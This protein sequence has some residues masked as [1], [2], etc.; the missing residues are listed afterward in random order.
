MKISYALF[1]ELLDGGFVTTWVDKQCYNLRF[2]RPSSCPDLF[3]HV[4]VTGMGKSGNSV[5]CRVGVSIVAG[6][7]Y[8]H[9][10]GLTATQHVFDVDADKTHGF[11]KLVT[12][13]N[14]RVWSIEAASTAVKVLPA[15]AGMKGGGLLINTAAAREAAREY[16]KHLPRRGWFEFYEE[17]RAEASDEELVIA[18]SLAGAAPSFDNPWVYRLVG[19]VLAR[20]GQR[21]EKRE[22]PF[23][24]ANIHLDVELLWRVHLLVDG[25]LREG[26]LWELTWRHKNGDAL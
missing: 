5:A 13:D 2:S 16:K 1:E 24:N 22:H 7:A 25:I 19:L 14:A 18:E 17:C 26:N 15:F 9:A 12:Q 11:T 3:E 4:W 10:K 20:H 8:A 6:G 23:A 21:V